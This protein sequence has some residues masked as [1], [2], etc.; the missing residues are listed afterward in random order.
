MMKIALSVKYLDGSGTV[1]DA[2]VPD[3]IAFER[4]YDKPVSSFAND[5]RI[6]YMCFLA[7][8]AAKRQ[9]HTNQDFD[10]WLESVA[11]LTVV[12]EDDIAPL[13]S[14]PPTGG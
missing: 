4:R 14:N 9:N 11:E 1:V 2:S 8:H 12:N 7:W 3:F 13:E 5:A 6:E 10:P